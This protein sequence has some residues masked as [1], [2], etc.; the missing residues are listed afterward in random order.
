MAVVLSNTASLGASGNVLTCA[1]F[2]AGASVAGTDGADIGALGGQRLEE[3]RPYMGRS[4][5]ASR[6]AAATGA[7]AGEAAPV[8]APGAAGA[9]GD[10]NGDFSSPVPSP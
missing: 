9:V 5:C 8:V 2:G 4:P 10:R 6:P 7:A 1:G 3:E